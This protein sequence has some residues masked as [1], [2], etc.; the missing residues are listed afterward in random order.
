MVDRFLPGGN[1]VRG[2]HVVKNGQGHA[3]VRCG[4]CALGVGSDAMTDTGVMLSTFAIA[5]LCGAIWEWVL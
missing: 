4:T 2:V 1:V 5:V 3:R